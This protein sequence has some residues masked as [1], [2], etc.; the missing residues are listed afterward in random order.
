MNLYLPAIL[1][2]WCP[3]SWSVIAPDGLQP[4]VSGFVLLAEDGGGDGEIAKRIEQ[5]TGLGDT[6]TVIA[7]IDLPQAHIHASRWNAPERLP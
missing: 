3:T 4:V 1:G 2:S 6:M 5:I 7:R